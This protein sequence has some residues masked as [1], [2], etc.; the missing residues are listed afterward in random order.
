MARDKRLW[1][2][3]LATQYIY[4]GDAATCATWRGWAEAKLQHMLKSSPG[5]LSATFVPSDGVE[6]RI[7]TRPNRVSVKTG[8]GGKLFPLGV[9]SNGSRF[10]ICPPKQSSKMTNVTPLTQNL[11]IGTPDNLNEY[12]TRPVFLGSTGGR[13]KVPLAF[14]N[15]STLQDRLFAWSN[16]FYQSNDKVQ[17]S[18]N[19]LSLINNTGVIL[20]SKVIGGSVHVL[21]RVK[22]Y[23]D[24]YAYPLNWAQYAEIY[25][26][27]LNNN[28]ETQIFALRFKHLL[29]G[30]SPV[31]QYGMSMQLVTEAGFTDLVTIPPSIPPGTRQQIGQYPSITVLDARFNLDGSKISILGG[32]LEEEWEA[33][34]DIL[35]KPSTGL[36]LQ[37]G[38]VSY[39]TLIDVVISRGQANNPLLF[40]ALT[41][42]E[43]PYE[44]CNANA[45]VCYKLY[46]KIQHPSV[47]RTYTYKSHNYSEQERFAYFYIMFSYG[48]NPPSNP[49]RYGGVYDRVNWF[50]SSSPPAR[51]SRSGVKYDV[52]SVE[53]LADL[54]SLDYTVVP[55]TP[56]PPG[57][58]DETNGVNTQVVMSATVDWAGPPQPGGAYGMYRDLVVNVTYADGHS[59]THVGRYDSNAPAHPYRCTKSA[60]T[61]EFELKYIFKNVIPVGYSFDTDKNSMTYGHRRLVEYGY[62]QEIGTGIN[63][64]LEAIQTFSMDNMSQNPGDSYQGYG[65]FSGNDFYVD[66]GAG[67][68]VDVYSPSTIDTDCTYRMNVT[69]GGVFCPS[70]YIGN[71]AIA[72]IG[73]SGN[74]ALVLKTGRSW[75][76]THITSGYWHVSVGASG[77]Q[78]S[79]QIQLI[80]QKSI[81]SAANPTGGIYDACG[82]HTLPTYF[83]V[84]CGGINYDEGLSVSRFSL[85]SEYSTSALT[86]DL[87]PIYEN[88]S[89]IGTETRKCWSSIFKVSAPTGVFEM[90]G[91]SDTTSIVQYPP[92]WTTSGAPYPPTGNATDLGD[93]GYFI[94]FAYIGLQ[95]PS[96]QQYDR[97]FTT[98]Y[99]LPSPAYLPYHTGISDNYFNSMVY[100]IPV[101]LENG[102]E[103]FE[104]VTVYSAFDNGFTDLITDY[105]NNKADF[106]R[107]GVS[108][109]SSDGQLLANTTVFPDGTD[110]SS[111][112]TEYNG[113]RWNVTSGYTID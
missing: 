63:E 36:P 18:K 27:K 20:D 58:Q 9:L 92:G 61:A 11:V 105:P 65:G 111:N 50:N 53:E 97:L 24:D 33:Q 107:V 100:K 2:S 48:S 37:T 66:A 44:D 69:Q 39:A 78:V 94:N 55:G 109:H 51:F 5:P 77:V 88:V 43:T 31:I 41:V 56:A 89:Y 72:R 35:V 16:P 42:S 13:D 75:E 84:R 57:S 19:L 12:T 15:F 30:A 23:D 60:F 17:K 76:A 38:W 81:A 74:E 68:E 32:V 28:I 104:F 102:I 40:N 7:D 103:S 3:H 112:P 73:D 62:K 47:D 101:T 45:P 110:T 67:E 83:S 34:T 71:A 85:E 98:T 52:Q 95:V 108:V 87:Y 90:C 99:T 46:N 8:E 64:T 4:D 93:S 29:S 59:E 86:S 79:R 96:Q 1:Q 54:W 10:K 25:Y 106:K 14:G 70:L 80:D 91:I 22:D 49:S 21:Y 113:W 82:Q 6:I 26:V